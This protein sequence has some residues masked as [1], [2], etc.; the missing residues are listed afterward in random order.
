MKFEK[1][2]ESSNWRCSGKQNWGIRE[3]LPIH[4]AEESSKGCGISSAWFN[5]RTGKVEIK[6]N[7]CYGTFYYTPIDSE[8]KAYVNTL[9]A[10]RQAINSSKYG[11]EEEKKWGRIWVNMVYGK[12][13]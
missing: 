5:E 4:D 12:V 6:E 9:T 11:S 3:G 13:G 2:W 10:V 8:A 7:G 1:V